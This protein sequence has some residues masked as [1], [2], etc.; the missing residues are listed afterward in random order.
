MEQLRAAS[1]CAV[2]ALLGSAADAVAADARTAD[3]RATPESSFFAARRAE[4]LSARGMRVVGHFFP[5][6]ASQLL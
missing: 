3:A 4:L 1:A 2:A 5:A 6:G